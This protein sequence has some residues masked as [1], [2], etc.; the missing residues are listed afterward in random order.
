MI[1]KNQGKYGKGYVH[2]HKHIKPYD[3][4]FACH[5]YQDPV[6]PGSLGVE[7]ILQAMQVFVLQQNL[8]DGMTNPKFVQV[9]NNTTNWKYRGQI[10][11]QVDNMFLEVHVKTIDKNNQGLTLVADAFLWNEK[12]RIYQVTDLAIGLVEA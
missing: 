5:F 10:L 6:M 11:Q 3:W 8:A 1:A 12:T 4:Y 2:A 7:A 9:P